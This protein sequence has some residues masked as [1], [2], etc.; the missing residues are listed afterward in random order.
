M[1]FLT[2]KKRR[3]VNFLY[4]NHFRNTHVE[5]RLALR[6]GMSVCLHR[7]LRV[8]RSSPC[9]AA[10]AKG[11][12]RST[13][14]IKPQKL[15]RRELSCPAYGKHSRKAGGR[16]MLIDVII[17]GLGPT[18]RWLH[19]LFSKASHPGTTAAL[20]LPERPMSQ[21]RSCQ[22]FT[23]AVIEHLPTFD[24]THTVFSLVWGTELVPHPELVRYTFSSWG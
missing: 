13:K 18:Y 2:T 24:W 19:S 6:L 14:G 11:D 8:G 7:I 10:S 9:T 4:A 21:Q 20:H 3:Q 17:L 16:S 23:A 12:T 22:L 5:S 1:S 15:P